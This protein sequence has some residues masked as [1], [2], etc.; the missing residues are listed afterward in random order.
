MFVTALPEAMDTATS[1]LASIGSTV[2]AGNAA[3][4]PAT[5]GV[6]PPAAE[7]ASLLLALAFA[8]HAGVY[9]ATQG[10][11]SAVHAMFV[12]TLGASAASYAATEGFNAVTMV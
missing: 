7:P 10:I 2:A 5:L 6:V 1:G 4:A 8:T 9:Q 11:G 3:G 12:S